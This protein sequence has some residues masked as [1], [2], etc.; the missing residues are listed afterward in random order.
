MCD[1]FFSGF[2]KTAKHLPQNILYFHQSDISVTVPGHAKDSKVSTC[3]GFTRGFQ[4]LTIKL[5]ELHTITHSA[6]CHQTAP[7]PARG[8][9][10]FEIG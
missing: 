10:Y 9:F 6:W 4:F 5:T 3:A 8:I 7:H 1:D 2:R